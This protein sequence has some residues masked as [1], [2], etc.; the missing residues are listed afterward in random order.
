MKVLGDSGD[1]LT[2]S[3]WVPYKE[4]GRG[5][6]VSRRCNY[7]SRKLEYSEKKKNHELWNAGRLVDRKGKQMDFPLYLP[8]KTEPGQHLNFILN[9]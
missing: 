2:L 6:S 5:I 7:R 1:F 9:F 4:V 3:R 8:E